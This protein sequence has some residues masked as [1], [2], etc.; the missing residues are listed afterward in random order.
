MQTGGDV[1]IKTLSDGSQM[2]FYHDAEAFEAYVK[3]LDL[4]ICQLF[5]VFGSSPS[6]NI[7]SLSP[8][9]PSCLSS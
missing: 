6:T 5:P 2:F 9:D 1:T 7:T 3:E 4:I 8:T